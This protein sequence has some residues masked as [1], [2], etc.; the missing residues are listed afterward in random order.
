MKITRRQ[1]R[2]LINEVYK[3]YESQKQGERARLGIQSKL[4]SLESSGKYADELQANQLALALGSKELELPA[5]LFKFNLK[6][7][8]VKNKARAYLQSILDYCEWVNSSEERF[9]PEDEATIK[10]FNQK[11]YDLGQEYVKALNSLRKKLGERKKVDDQGYVTFGTP[12]QQ[13]FYTQIMSY[14]IS[15]F[16]DHGSLI[17]AIARKERKYAQLGRPVKPSKCRDMYN[18]RKFGPIDSYFGNKIK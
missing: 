2:K 10:N 3:D 9:T 14:S 11:T 12:E 7:E 1:L 13:K 18:Y 17:A 16:D 5:K 8:K 15:P 4:S 6:F